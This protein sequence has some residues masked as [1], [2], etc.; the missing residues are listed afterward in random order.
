MST[1]LDAQEEVWLHV[2]S[3]LCRAIKCPLKMYLHA[4]RVRCA[5]GV[6][7]CDELLVPS[8]QEPQPAGKLVWCH[9]T[10]IAWQTAAHL[11]F[12][13]PSRAP[14]CRQACLCC[15][16]LTSP[17]NML[18]DKAKLWAPQSLDVWAG[19]HARSSGRM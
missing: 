15:R 4:M 17:Q 18:L 6:V 19:E 3:C 5:G 14:T 9:A 8:H 1:H 13:T 11:F 7:A 10:E 12:A 2:M 16:R